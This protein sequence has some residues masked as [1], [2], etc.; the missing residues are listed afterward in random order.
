MGILIVDGAVVELEDEA[1]E[2]ILKNRE[3]IPPPLKIG[4]GCSQ[5]KKIFDRLSSNWFVWTVQSKSVALSWPGSTAAI[6]SLEKKKKKKKGRG[7]V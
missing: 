1:L 3:V 4:P 7:G 5:R 2:L 6:V